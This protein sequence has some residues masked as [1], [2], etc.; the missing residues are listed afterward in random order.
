MKHL[1]IIQTLYKAGYEAYIVGGAV[2]DHILD[3]EAKDFDITTNATPEECKE[4]FPNS[5][6]QYVGKAFGV[7]LIDGIEVA[8]FRKDIHNGIGDKFCE[9]KYADTLKEDLSRRDFTINAMALDIDNNLIDIYNGKR[10]IKNKVIRFVGNPNRR[11]QED[12]NRIIRACR[13]LARI[14]GRFSR[15]TRKALRLNAHLIIKSVAPDRIRVEIMKA[16]ET[17][18]ASL[19]FS[20]LHDIG[21]LRYIFPELDKAVNHTGGQHHP[22]TVFEHCMMAG[23][24][25]S[26]RFPL[27]K[28]SLYLHD[29]GKPQAWLDEKRLSNGTDEGF[30]GHEKTGEII[31][32]HDLTKL[33]FSHK[34][35]EYVAGLI[36]LH[37]RQ[38]KDITSKSRRKLLKAMY[39]LNVDWKD[40]VMFRV[41]DTVSNLKR[42]EIIPSD[43]HL[44]T[45]TF[46]F[47]NEVLPVSAHRLALSGGEI[48]SHF[49]LTASP[50]IG[51]IQKHLYDF[52]IEYG[53]EVNTKKALLAK[54]EE[55]LK[56]KKII[57]KRYI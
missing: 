16:M 5:D 18:N 51:K 35:T 2:R 43:V 54:T 50:L 29:I 48:I 49:D 42:G 30:N 33:K 39:D 57:W 11:I 47:N 15:T 3:I 40:M 6:V 14:E 20:A 56:I 24:F 4:I 52:V 27:L 53:S 25:I 37:M 21:A 55:I 7:S 46:V 12:P 22:E 34:E 13:F 44:M 23:D 32:R 31:V 38:L 36:R 19:F 41:A 9:I 28:L 8:T 10:D 17:K 45:K 1:E 26:T